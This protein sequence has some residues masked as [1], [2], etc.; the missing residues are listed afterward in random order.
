VAFFALVAV[1][2]AVRFSSGCLA[3]F[4]PEI[5]GLHDLFY[6]RDC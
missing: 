1:L 3:G 2:V 6:Q 5:S 4:A